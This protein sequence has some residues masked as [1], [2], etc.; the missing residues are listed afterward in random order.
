[1]KEGIKEKSS[2]FDHPDEC[3]NIAE[4]MMQE[5]QIIGLMESRLNEPI[6]DRRQKGS[7]KKKLMKQIKLLKEI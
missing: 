3:C 1:M 5:I 6:Y 4:S 2:P 7:M